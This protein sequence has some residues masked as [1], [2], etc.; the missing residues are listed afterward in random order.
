MKNI[1]PNIFKFN[2]KVLKYAFNILN[3]N[4]II[5]VPTETVY[6]LAGSA[7][8]KNAVKKIYNIKKRPKKNPLIIHYYNLKSADRDIYINDDLKKIYKKLCP[9]PITFVVKR[10]KNSRIV[11]PAS[12]NL[13][14]VAIRFPKNTIIRK[15][16]KKLNFPLAIPSAN[17]S[18]GI[19]PICALDVYDEFKKNVKMIIDGGSARIGIEST[20]IDLTGKSQI[21]RPGIIS[22]KK[23]STIL[24]KKILILKSIKKIKSPGQI[25][26][27][28]SP[29]IP[30][31]LNYNKKVK[32]AAHI[33][34]GNKFKNYNNAFQLSKKANLEEAA[35]NLYKIFR[36]IKKLNYKKIYV[37]TIPNKGIGVALNDRLKHASYLK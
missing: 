28:Y 22:E 34:F 18:S 33:V 11:R 3:L 12:A 17:K 5:A 6:G 1:Y 35:K 29:G 7:Y 14:T 19:S 13:D 15:L 36:K 26:K 16:L 2:K 4:Q 37:S 31:V 21:L 24:K 25:K 23:I 20:V 8:S 30:M 32:N 9:G 10:K 27:H